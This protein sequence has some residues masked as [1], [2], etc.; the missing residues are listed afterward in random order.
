MLQDQADGIRQKVE[1]LEEEQR[2]EAV[3]RARRVAFSLEQ[4]QE[5]LRGLYTLAGQRLTLLADDEAD[6][7]A[8]V[9]TVTQAMIDDLRTEIDEIA[10]GLGDAQMPP[11]RRLAA[12]R[13]R[14]RSSTPSTPTSRPRARWCPSTT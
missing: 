10:G 8:A 3:D 9:P 13:G 11:P 12:L 2:S 7:S 1:R 14:A 5:R 4:V 6:A